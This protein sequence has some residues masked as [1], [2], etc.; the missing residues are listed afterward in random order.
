M[1]PEN[2]ILQI[3]VINSGILTDFSDLQLQNASFSMEETVDG[4]WTDF[5]FE[6]LKKHHH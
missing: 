5:I 4:I 3:E 6:H 2:A 1:H